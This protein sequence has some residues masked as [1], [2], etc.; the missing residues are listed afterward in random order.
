MKRAE[1]DRHRSCVPFALM[2]VGLLATFCNTATVQAQPAWAQ[3]PAA[4]RTP[5]EHDLPQTPI[6][7]RPTATM[8][9][10]RP[11]SSVV[12]P[13]EFSADEVLR[14][15]LVDVVIEGND[16]IREFA[17]LQRIE[18]RPGRPPVPRQIQE[19]VARLLNTRWF[20]SVR[21]LYRQTDE[22][23]VL[24]F[25]VTERPILR[26]VQFVGNEK[27]KTAELQAHLGLRPG[28][29]YDV[30][31]NRESVH[32]IKSLYREKGYRFAEVELRSGSQPDERDVI[33][34]IEEGPR[35]RV[36]SIQFE[37]NSFTRDAVLKTKV[38]T[39]TVIAGFFGGDYDP[40]V[41]KNDVLA[42]TEYYQGLGFFDV[43][44]DY[45]EKLSQKRDRIT[46]I[47]KI[48]EG[49]RYKV[50]KIEVVGN[51]VI[52]R[53]RLLG[54][55][56]LEEGEPFNARFMREDVAGMK[57]QYDEL[58]RLFAKVEPVPVFREDGPGWVD[59]VYRID[60][61]V[62]RYIGT[63]NIHVRGDHPHTRE[64][65]V[66]QQVH[67]FLK[68]GQL[69]N[70]SDIR[71]ARAR[72]QNS[73]LWERS[74][75]V[76]F[77]IK[78][79]AGDD[80]LPSLIAR[81]Q[82][83]LDDSRTGLIETSDT[84]RDPSPIGHS[85]PLA[86]GSDP[87]A[88]PRVN[89][90]PTGRVLLPNRTEEPQIEAPTPASSTTT[91]QS[92]I[93]PGTD[94]GMSGSPALHPDVIFRGQ[95]PEPFLYRAQSTNQYGQPVPQDYLQRVSP[96]GD[97]FGD[98]LSA[99]APPGFV[100][101][102]IDVTEGRTGRLMF[103]VGVNS[104]AGVIGSLVLQE[105][106][107][108]ILRPPRSW[109]D[110]MN[111]QAWRGAGQSFR[112]EA[113][114]GSEVSRYVVSWQDPYFMRSDFSLGLS[115][116]Y[117]NRFY[118][119]WTEDRLGGRISVGHV[120][121]RF[122]S[123]GAAVRLEN[124]QVR[125]FQRPAPADLEAVAG[126]NFL[127]TGSITMT[128]DSRDSA[129]TPS[130]GNFAEFTY[131]QAFGE[132]DYPRFELSGGQYF[133]V[134][135][136]P[137]GLGKHIVQLTGEFGWTGNN[138]PIFERFY[139]GG[140]SSFRGFAFRGVSPRDSNVRVGGQFMAIG[141]AEYMIPVTASD[142]IRA[143]V[144]SDFGTV[145]PDVTFDQFRVTAGF[146]FRVLLPAMGPAPLAFDFAWPIVKDE[147]DNTRVF[148]FYIGFTR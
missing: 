88:A 43:Q 118:E 21:P 63:I 121:D 65:V 13:V 131:E 137:D 122:W 34:V 9:P 97:P 95:T 136:R 130:E 142:N 23:P 126:D 109:A 147:T 38:S 10:S 2:L 145:E 133:T 37:G 101:I 86:P 36:G 143:V 74:D 4:E 140:Y 51:E 22:G 139:A 92:A 11:V 125:D 107:F 78:P 119:E 33:F 19:D 64:E 102:N 8:I 60:E 25:S 93:L 108:D 113:V 72:V 71:I 44:V 24:V 50:G 42:L 96:Q 67:R 128:Y 99:P 100:D 73:P 117:Y 54:K 104:D 134:Y 59:L 83:T 129:F 1:T 135:E 132:F 115:G 111:G 48:D 12:L 35:V 76:V 20:F 15:P 82:S 106:N 41:V 52:D 5:P 6:Q 32:R 56:E 91:S 114:P 68:P 3:G 57:D 18:T 148:S 116:F 141:S 80:Y 66:R 39:K 103:G 45:E 28:H 30:S 75:P 123:I 79:V 87:V 77:D 58:G 17:I 124:V 31:A 120:L 69:A 81:G 7:P 29:A 138:T 53:E 90:Q 146:G 85:L 27:I 61:D 55:L 105:D 46:V 49:E 84:A 26:S 47:F 62:P 16:T 89:R 94:S 14:D 40:E 112:L 110:V 98:A 144:F 70:G 127:S